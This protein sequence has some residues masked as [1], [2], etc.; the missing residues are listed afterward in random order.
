MTRGAIR[1][2]YSYRRSDAGEEE[3]DCEPDVEGNGF[4]PSVVAGID[5]VILQVSD[6]IQR[7]C[8]NLLNVSPRCLIS[9]QQC[10][11]GMWASQA[12]YLCRVMSGPPT[13]CRIWVGSRLL[14]AAGGSDGRSD[15]AR[16][17]S[18]ISIGPHRGVRVADRRRDLGRDCARR[19]GLPRSERRRASNP[20]R[21]RD[22]NPGLP[23]HWRIA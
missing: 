3:A 17:R 21:D 23:W 1:S 7:L 8:N 19:R 22:G 5:A 2:V 16:P 12:H 18:R 13:T 11:L 15:S 4:P 14:C 10:R 6:S 20:G 9:C